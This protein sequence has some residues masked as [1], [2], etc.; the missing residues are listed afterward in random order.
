M[1]TKLSF[2]LPVA[3]WTAVVLASFLWNIR[4]LDKGTTLT[5]KSIGHSFFKEIQTTR[6]WNARHR[7]VY[8]PVTSVTQPNPYLDDPER[9]VITRKGLT[10]TKINPAYMT[11]QIAEIT[12]EEGHVQ[13]HITS[14]KPIRP[15]NKPDA[16]EQAALRK[17]EAGSPDDSE[18]VENGASYRYMAPL[19]VKRACLK[20]HAKQGYKEG[21][22]RGGIS[23]T[24]PT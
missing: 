16:W 24:I 17:F 13:F 15:G 14:L 12:K 4:M 9:D 20:C 8:V 18:F 23:V 11:R 5:L 21:E 1:K 7:G 3:L 19:P 2:F 6:L 10:L 22:I